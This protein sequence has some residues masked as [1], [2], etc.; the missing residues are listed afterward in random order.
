MHADHAA[1]HLGK[2]QG[3]TMM[4]RSLPHNCAQRIV[5]LPTDVLVRHKVSQE[6]VLRGQRDQSVKD[7][8]F[9]VASRAKQHLDKV[10]G[11]RYFRC[12]II[13]KTDNIT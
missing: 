7:A 2:A 4:V 10:I 5:T 13:P 6:A 12:Y 11:E 3:I 9:D 8:V 1:S